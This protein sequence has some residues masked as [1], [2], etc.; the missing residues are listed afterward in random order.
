MDHIARAMHA[1]SLSLAIRSD[2]ASHIKGR[3][4]H[5]TVCHLFY[6][7]SHIMDS[8]T[9]TTSTTDLN[10]MLDNIDEENPPFLSCKDCLCQDYTPDP[11]TDEITVRIKLC[12]LHKSN[13]HAPNPS[14]PRPSQPIISPDQSVVV[15]GASRTLPAGRRIR[16]VDN[17]QAPDAVVVDFPSPDT[18]DTSTPQRSR[19]PRPTRA[20]PNRS[21]SPLR[22]PLPSASP[23]A[24]RGLRSTCNL[25]ADA[26]STYKRVRRL[27][28]D[29][30]NRRKKIAD[31]LA[32]ESISRRTWHRKR[33]IAELQILDP[34]LFNK[35]LDKALSNPDMNKRRLNQEVLSSECSTVLARP[36]M[37][38]KKRRAVAA[39]KLL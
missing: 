23:S 3:A 25:P 28:L 39:G 32:T 26:L 18:V 38:A 7:T 10:N 6:S 31:I 37:I 2:V 21:R 13:L 1:T 17:Q 5:N 29:P 11:V 12:S 9:S 34:A 27:C 35:L 33:P 14:P 15:P 30:T 8:T 16:D 36:V 19:S 4:N 22:R 20:S 24:D